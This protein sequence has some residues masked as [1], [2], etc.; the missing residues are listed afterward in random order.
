MSRANVWLFAHRPAPPTPGQTNGITEQL[1]GRFQVSK[2]KLLKA[3]FMQK[4]HL[5]TR[6][7]L[8]SVWISYFLF[9]LWIKIN[10][11]TLHFILFETKTNIILIH[12]K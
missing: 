2:T 1:V 6:M 9:S 12:V 4:R 3:N 10:F 8:Q 7:S 5:L 11:L